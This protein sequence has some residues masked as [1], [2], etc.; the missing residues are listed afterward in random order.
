MGSARRALQFSLWTDV[1]TGHLI[2]SNFSSE[3]WVWGTHTPFF[4]RK[5]MRKLLTIL[6]IFRS[7]A[8]SAR[9]VPAGIYSPGQLED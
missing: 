7:I 1:G 5:T 3:S 4:E 2:C 6:L 9:S 8:T